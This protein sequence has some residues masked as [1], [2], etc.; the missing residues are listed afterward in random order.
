MV[1]LMTREVWVTQRRWTG[2]KVVKGQMNFAFNYA[3]CE[4]LSVNG[5]KDFSSPELIF[6]SSN[7][8]HEAIRQNLDLIF[9][10][11]D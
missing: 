7:Y 10:K 8:W 9:L 5:S 3:Q 2:E 11:W 1:S 4:T 6:Q